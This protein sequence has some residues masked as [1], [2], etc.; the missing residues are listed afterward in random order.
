M[1]FTSRNCFFLYS[2]LFCL[3]SASSLK[4]IKMVLSNSSSLW[5]IRIGAVMWTQKEQEQNQPP[6]LSWQVKQ[7]PLFK[8]NSL[9]SGLQRQGRVKN[10]TYLVSPF[11]W[12]LE[13]KQKRDR[14]AVRRRKRSSEKGKSSIHFVLRCKMHSMFRHLF[15]LASHQFRVLP[16]GL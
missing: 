7:G 6:L 15:F 5:I 12:L 1:T 9:L 4:V 11:L 16:N 8:F 13:K 2:R 14:K 10:G 3:S